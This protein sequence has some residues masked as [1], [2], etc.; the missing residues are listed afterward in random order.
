M[1]SSG[2]NLFIEQGKYY[3]SIIIFEEIE[4]FSKSNQDQGSL[5]L[6][7]IIILL[8]TFSSVSCVVLSI[9]NNEQIETTKSYIVF[10]W[11]LKKSVYDLFWG[12]KS[13]LS[14]SVFVAL[15]AAE[16]IF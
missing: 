5:F 7:F 3:P 12:G 2:E 15:L 13:F 14:F 11:D 16:L 4:N 8:R 10:D 6:V 1:S 9:Y